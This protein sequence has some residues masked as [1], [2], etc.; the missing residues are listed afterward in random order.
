[1][2][3]RLD[4]NVIVNDLTLFPYAIPTIIDGI[5]VFTIPLGLVFFTSPSS[6]YADT[7]SRN[8]WR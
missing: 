8:P 2:A 6:R 1:M 3:N 7:G 5:C 4:G